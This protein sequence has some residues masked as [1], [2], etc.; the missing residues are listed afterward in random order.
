MGKVRVR[1]MGRIRITAVVI[2][3]ICGVVQKSIAKKV[4]VSIFA[5]LF[6]SS[7][8]TVSYTHLTLP[9]KRIV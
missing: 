7:I 2:D 4:L 3:G 9:T 8:G 5:I 6:I 1:A